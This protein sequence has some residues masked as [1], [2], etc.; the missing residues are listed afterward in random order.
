M[1]RSPFAFV[2]PALA[3]HGFSKQA[4]ERHALGDLVMN[5]AIDRDHVIVGVGQRGNRRRNRFL[6]GHWP[7]CE[8]E[9]ARGKPSAD[10]LVHLMNARHLAI[11]LDENI[12]IDPEVLLQGVRRHGGSSLF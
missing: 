8:L 4:L 5:A 9:S 2:Q 10:R 7:V 12:R 1:W 3:R 11:D 6:A